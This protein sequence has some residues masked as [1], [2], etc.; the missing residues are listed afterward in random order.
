METTLNPWIEL[1]NGENNQSFILREEQSIIRKFNTKVSSQYKIHSSI[2]PAPFMGNVHTA[3]VVVLG[4]NPGYD[5]KEEE[6]GYYRKYENWWMQQIQHKL[7]CPQ[8]PLFCL[9]KEY[10]EQSP[11]WGQK[12]KPLIALVGRE[13]VAAN[14]AKIQFFPYHSKK[15]K[16][17]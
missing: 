16:T 2:F 13:K 6:R 10:E 1:A 7:P 12:L 5:E 3:P 14:L 17:L 15:F 9:E 4:L 11:Y 8:W